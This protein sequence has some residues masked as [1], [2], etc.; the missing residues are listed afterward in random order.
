MPDISITD[1][2]GKPVSGVT[3]DLSSPS[4]IFNYLRTRL[5]HLIVVPDFIA[6]KDETLTQAAPKPIQ[7]QAKVGNTFQLGATTPVISFSA[8]VQAIIRVNA[9]SGSKLFDQDAFVVQALVP[10]A[11]AYFSAELHGSTGV[12]VS[13]TSGDLTFGFASSADVAINY[14]KAFPTG[15]G[16]STLAGA[17]GAVL[18]AYVIP[19]SLADLKRLQL[20]DICTASGTGSLKVSGSLSVALP[21]N[22][23]ASVNLPLGAGTVT[24]KDGVM[25][26]VAA[27]A[28]V[29]G[30]Y[31]VR[32][33]RTAADTIELSYL[34]QKGSTLKADLS[35]SGGV[36]VMFGKTDLLAAL[37]GVIS[38]DPTDNQKLLDGLTTA[39]IHTLSAAIK[40]GAD[41][42][43]QV[44]L[45]QALAA[46]TDDEAAFQYQ[47]DPER[48]DETSA[49]A[50]EL[51]LRGDLSKLGG[52]EA[53]ME[54]D[55]T[56]A[57][58]LK[59]VN[60][61]FLR[62]RKT[63]VALRVNLLGIVNLLSLSNL[64][65]SGEVI[66]DPVSGDLTFK[67]TVTGNSINAI[68]HP[69]DRQAA[70]QKA[71]FDS[72]IVTTAYRASKAVTL[73]NM[74]CHHL[75]FAAEQKTS[76]T[77][78]S[79]YLNWF[80]ALNLLD[81]DGKAQFLKQFAEGGAS[82]CLLRTEFDDPSCGAM[83]LDSQGNPRPE[84]EYLDIARQ[85]LRALLD[86]AKSDID[87]YRYAML[88]DPIWPEALSKG[89]SG[90][91]GPLL[92]IPSTHPQYSLVLGNVIGD[93]YDIQWWGHSMHDAAQELQAMR[94]FLKSNPTAAHEDSAEFES[95]KARLQQ[96]MAK[97]VGASK[98]RFDNPFGMVAMFWAAGSPNASGKLVTSQFTVQKQFP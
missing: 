61:A 72:V 92:P 18:S 78:V 91:L 38:T 6:R 95:R 98:L 44:G 62:L 19:A 57:P 28:A 83:F 10:A 97:V 49:A 4:S 70:L 13:G 63:E 33:R 25:A 56:I 53:N 11:T 2:V 41:H 73:S 55:G 52:L 3:V 94:A 48:L 8:G 79:A 80:I 65:R 1:D 15:T 50:V 81:K 59:V 60:S 69:Y 14:L 26:G 36:S 74:N 30:S 54:P 21:V 47:I 51:A 85:A 42:S 82:T 7:F 67:E 34:K 71:V 31:Q 75:H 29:T 84:T 45:D 5:F 32:A 40:A 16:E 23:L 20:N 37:L 77:T 93:M 39:E 43:L 90:A 24:V 9:T 35:V 27:S 68:T 86:P 89:A 17:L 58:G 46:V 76:S 87:R 22:P 66:T 88:D 96:L 12:G 64:I